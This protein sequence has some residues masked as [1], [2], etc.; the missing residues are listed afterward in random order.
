MARRFREELGCRYSMPF[1]IFNQSRK[2]EYWMIHA[3]D[4]PE[5]IDLMRRAYK[6]IACGYDPNREQFEFWSDDDLKATLSSVPTWDG[7][8]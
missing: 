5:A 6:R 4:H 3:T 7:L 2:T 8:L 1:P